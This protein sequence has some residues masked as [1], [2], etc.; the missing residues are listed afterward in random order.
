MNTTVEDDEVEIQ[1][2][3]N[4]D[5][6]EEF[7]AGE[8]EGDPFDFEEEV[9]K[10]GFWADDAMESDC[11][12]QNGDAACNPVGVRSLF[13]TWTDRKNQT[14]APARKLVVHDPVDNRFAV[15]RERHSA[16]EIDQF[17][18]LIGVCGIHPNAL[19]KNIH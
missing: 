14:E 10:V 11:E 7:F 12:Y 2:L 9:G 16:L 17:V 18:S 4:E 1:T 8:L 15:V 13:V 3:V 6:L 19:P 5:E